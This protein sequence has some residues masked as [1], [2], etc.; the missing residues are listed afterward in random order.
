MNIVCTCKCKFEKN[1]VHYF[2]RSICVCVYKISY[3]NELGTNKGSSQC[4]Y[5]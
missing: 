5:K 4:T 3:E 2:R 1:M